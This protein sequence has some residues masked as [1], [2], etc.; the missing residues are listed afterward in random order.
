MTFVPR[1]WAAERLTSGC[2]GIC[3]AVFNHW[4]GGGLCGRG[5]DHKVCSIRWTL[6]EAL[7]NNGRVSLPDVTQRV[8]IM[9]AAHNDTEYVYSR[10]GSNPDYGEIVEMFVEELPKRAASLLEHLDKGDWESLRRVAH[11]IKG[12]AGS[13]GFDT[14]SPIAGKLEATVRNSDPEAD[15]RKAIAE[16]ADI[17]NRA[18]AGQ[19]PA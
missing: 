18:R 7:S 6:R 2:D 15:I 11:Q 9:A 19:P 8:G 1:V 17:C 16:L 3:L 13:Y 10:L 14:I 5:V 4:G 12:A